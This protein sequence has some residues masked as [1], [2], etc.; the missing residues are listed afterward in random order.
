MKQSGLS[1]M[2]EYN[3]KTNELSLAADNTEYLDDVNFLC[4][5]PECSFCEYVERIVLK[6]DNLDFLP[7]DERFDFTDTIEV[8]FDAIDG[9]T[10]KEGDE[11]IAT[12]NKTFTIQISDQK[13]S[14]YE[15]EES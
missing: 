13:A 3:K 15:V 11:E 4:C 6:V 8:P 1:F 9:F 5:I 7:K 10:L 14:E 2:F 12:I